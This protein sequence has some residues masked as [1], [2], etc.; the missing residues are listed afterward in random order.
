MRAKEVQEKT[1]QKHGQVR[2]QRGLLGTQSQ[3]SCPRPDGTSKGFSFQNLVCAV[4]VGADSPCEM[5]AFGRGISHCH[6]PA[7]QRG[8]PGYS[9]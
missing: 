7:Q 8:R 4:A 3:Q 5:G 6:T 1:T 9:L 2:G